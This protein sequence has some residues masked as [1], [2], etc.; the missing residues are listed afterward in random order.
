[1]TTVLTRITEIKKKEGFDIWHIRSAGKIVKVTKSGVL[2]VWPYRNRTRDTHT[3][4]EFREKFAAAY[5]GC[6]CAVLR[7][8]GTVV[9][10]NTLLQQVRAT[11]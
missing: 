2:G 7:G 8:D 6:T 11:Y 4:K 9:H 1:M 10:G 5:P 3:V